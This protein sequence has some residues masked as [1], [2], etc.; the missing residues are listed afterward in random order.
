MNASALQIF[1]PKLCGDSSVVEKKILISQQEPSLKQD[2]LFFL[3]RWSLVKFA[4]KCLLSRIVHK[5]V[6]GDFIGD[7]WPG[8]DPSR[9]K[10]ALTPSLNSL[11]SF[12]ALQKKKIEQKHRQWVRHIG[13]DLYTKFN[14]Q[15]LLHSCTCCSVTLTTTRWKA[16]GFEIDCLMNRVKHNGIAYNNWQGS[17][18][19]NCTHDGSC[20]HVRPPQRWRR[21][22]KGML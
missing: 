13:F 20:T 10:K 12:F 19:Q 1:H 8:Q 7:W 9:T 15:R 18:Q 3:P 5:L 17:F 16:L 2:I 4:V 14:S 6:C 21:R 11:H 22:R